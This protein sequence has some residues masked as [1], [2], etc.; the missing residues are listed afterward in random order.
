MKLT[1]LLAI[2]ALLGAAQPAAAQVK[3]TGAGSSFSN[4]LYTDW[5]QTYNKAHADVQLNYQSIGSGAGIRQF[6]DGIIDFGASDAPMSDSAIAAIQGNVLHIPTEM[7]GVLPTYNLSD[8]TQAL[9]FTPE[10][11]AGIYLG[12]ITRWND[13]RIVSVNQGVQ[14]PATDI[15]VVHRSDGSGTSFIWT[16]YLSNVSAEWKEKVGKGT[17]VNWPVG[18]GG[19]GNEGVA[20]TVK[21]TP[22]AIGYVELGY[23]L[24]NHLPVGAV[25]NK[26]GRFITPSAASVTAA[27]AGAMKMMGP[28]TDFR[29]SIINAEGAEAYPI[30]SFTWMLVHKTYDDPAK[31]QALVQ[32]TWWTLTEGQERCEPLGYAGLPKEL[33][34][35][36]QARLKSVT[37]NGRSVWKAE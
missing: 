6:S 11:L 37:A 5:M 33:R 19:K 13:P 15:V 31:A 32:Y 26:A 21:Q 10:I 27:A 2:A 8:V 1:K 17:A 24:I 22:G 20:A 7:G 12:Q 28:N 18:L 35:W 25:R 3:I 34:P 30:S 16:D 9:K 4:I 14:L 36:I 23:A 29:V